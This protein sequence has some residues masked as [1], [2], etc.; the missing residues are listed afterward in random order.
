MAYN[1]GDYAERV[2]DHCDNPRNVGELADPDAVSLV[3]NPA[4]GDTTKLSLRIRGDVIV[5]AKFK[6]FGCGAAVA[7][8][9]MVTTMIEGMRLEEAE[10]LTGREVAEALGGLP[11]VK[12]HAAAL[13]ESSV[14]SALRS[15]RERIPGSGRAG[16]REGERDGLVPLP[17]QELER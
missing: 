1:S 10:R 16:E 17:R 12:K 9:S 3:E 2:L 15:Y 11:P 5:Q 14:R 7:A 13:A 8:S 6:T 4:C